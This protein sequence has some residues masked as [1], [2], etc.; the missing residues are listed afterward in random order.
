MTSLSLTHKFFLFVLIISVALSGLLYLF[1]LTQLIFPSDEGAAKE[2]TALVPPPPASAAMEKNPQ[3]EVAN[4]TPM[5]EVL[6]KAV[7]DVKSKRRK[8]D[9]KPAA[10]SLEAHQATSSSNDVSILFVLAS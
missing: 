5:V 7:V 8:K 2:D 4:E 1:Y 6:E 9:T 3:K 10:A